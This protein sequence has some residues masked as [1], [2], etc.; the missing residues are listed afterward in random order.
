[1]KTIM[2]FAFILIVGLAMAFGA[3]A[4]AGGSCCAS[5]EDSAKLCACCTCDPCTCEKC[6]C[7]KCDDCKCD[8]CSHC[9][10]K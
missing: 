3:M 10:K 5:A 6:E 9:G 2:V 8:S 7:C 4:W 1:M